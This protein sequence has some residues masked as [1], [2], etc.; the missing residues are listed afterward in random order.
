M[1]VVSFNFDKIHAEKKKKITGKIEISSNI[2]VKSIT[3]DKI[4]IMKDKPVLKIEFEFSILYKPEIAEITFAGMI[5]ALS[6][7]EEVKSVLKKWKTKDI[8]NEI[9][10]PLFNMIMTKCNLKALQLEEE[11]NLP[12]HVPLPRLKPE[13]ENNRSYTG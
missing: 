4:E 10:V 7:K 12:T 8:P 3:Q 9:R 11:L 13:Q 5:L 1:Q 2:N 6:E